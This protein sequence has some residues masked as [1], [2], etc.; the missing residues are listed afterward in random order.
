MNFKNNQ[1]DKRLD[2]LQ[3]LKYKVQG[4]MIS[5]SEKSKAIDQFTTK[6]EEDMTSSMAF[7]V[8]QR[9]Q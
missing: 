3:D 2:A 7:L 5:E 1:I 9:N 6:I 8:N 4:L